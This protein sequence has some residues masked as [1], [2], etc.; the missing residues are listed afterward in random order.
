MIGAQSS[1]KSKIVAHLKKLAPF[2]VIERGV[3]L[4]VEGRVVECSCTGHIITGVVR[5][6]ESLSHS[7]AISVVS[8]HEVDAS[9]S[10][11]LP[12]EMQ[13]Q[14]CAHA[15]AILYR[16]SE[17]DFFDPRGGFGERE[18]TFRINPNSP[19]DVAAAIRE[20]SQLKPGAA[21]ND[22][23]LTATT[24]LSTPTVSI[25]L[26]LSSDRLGVRVAF[27]EHEQEP[28]IFEGFRTVSSRALDNILL[29]VLEDEGS[30]DESTRYWYIN[31]SRG[32]EL[33]LGLIEEYDTVLSVANVQPIRVS[34]ESIH[35]KLILL[36]R[37]ESLELSMRWVV[38]GTDQRIEVDRNQE[39]FGT[40]PFWTMVKN[41]IYRLSPQ[42]ARVASIFGTTHAVSIPRSQVGPILEALHELQTTD[43]EWI[44]ISPLLR[45]RH[46]HRFCT[47]SAEISQPIILHLPGR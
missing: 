46:R 41:T 1:A 13:E 9:C 42:A 25:L 15:V 23:G 27:D 5:E 17:L 40:G 16:A 14:W 35:A 11:C 21:G 34:H 24:T 29:Q 26:D 2:S 30:W 44:T 3:N 28:T 20:V 19:T 33:V 8:A 12:S 18:S 47:S 43:Q 36:W 38:P 37:A 22:L 32:I 10:C 45:L 31:S 7:V 6:D 4:S 39:V